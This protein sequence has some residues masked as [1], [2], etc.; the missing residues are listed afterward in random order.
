MKPG[1]FEKKAI[2]MGL[3]QDQLLTLGEP[4][5]LHLEHARIISNKCTICKSIY[6]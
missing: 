4:G 1:L 3:V 2:D 6:R 5:N